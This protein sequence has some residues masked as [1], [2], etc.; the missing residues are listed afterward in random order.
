MPGG[1]ARATAPPFAAPA[2]PAALPLAATSAWC[3]SHGALVYA[4]AK[5]LPALPLCG[6]GLD[7]DGSWN[8]VDLPGPRGVT[9]GRYYDVISFSGV[10]SFRDP[11]DGHVAVVVASS[12]DPANGN[13]T[14]EIAQE[15][16]PVATMVRTLDLVGW[17]LGDPEE[18]VDAEWQPSPPTRALEGEGVD[19]EGVCSDE[20]RQWQFTPADCSRSKVFGGTTGPRLLV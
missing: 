3:T 10:A 6:P 15:N 2:A 17:R 13:G 18:P 9:S 20:A 8:Y 12:V 1:N 14:V 5:T 7:F 19:Q 4:W 11:T 16:V